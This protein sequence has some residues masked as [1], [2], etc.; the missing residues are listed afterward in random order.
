METITI[1]ENPNPNQT[2]T[3]TKTQQLNKMQQCWITTSQIYLHHSFCILGSANINKEE[4][5]KHLRARI[6]EVC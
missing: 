3:T 6:P 2:K 5:E 1:T 4:L